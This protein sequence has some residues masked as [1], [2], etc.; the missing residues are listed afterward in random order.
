MEKTNTRR[1]FT[2]LL[3]GGNTL[4]TSPL[5]GEDVRRTEEGVLGKLFMTPPLPAFGHPLPQGARKTTHGFTLIEL[6]VVVLIIGILA[7]VAVPQ[8]QK[9]VERARTTEAITTLR[10][11]AVAIDTYILENGTSTPVYFTKPAGERTELTLDLVSSLDCIGGG[12]DMGRVCASEH[13]IYRAW[14][15]NSSGCEIWANR[16]INSEFWNEIPDDVTH[17]K[18]QMNRSFASNKWRYS[19]TSNDNIGT[20]VCASLRTQ[21]WN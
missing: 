16:S 21:G 13:F 11:F 2:Q 14:C 6:L 12:Y 1:G 17:Y 3:V 4:F 7:A 10:N 9:A 19:C 20:K 18:L 15:P 8:Y 5:E